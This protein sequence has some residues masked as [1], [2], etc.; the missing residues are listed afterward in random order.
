MLHYPCITS[1]VYALQMVNATKAGFLAQLTAVLVPVLSAAA[2]SRVSGRVWGAACLALT[3]TCA[4]ALDK[5][6]RG[7]DLAALSAGTSPALVEAGDMYMVA[8]T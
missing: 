5:A 2:G 1:Q 6:T 3:G 4:I 8:G 7:P